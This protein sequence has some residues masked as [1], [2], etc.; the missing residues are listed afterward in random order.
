MSVST[1]SIHLAISSSVN[2]ELLEFCSRNVLSG[3]RWGVLY[4]VAGSWTL[5]TPIS[6]E[7]QV[8]YRIV[9]LIGLTEM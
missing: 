2:C 7:M 9:V 8:T 3:F 6:F 5:K 1:L 4:G